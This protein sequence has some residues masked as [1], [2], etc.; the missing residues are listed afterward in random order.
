MEED[1]DSRRPE[2]GKNGDISGDRSLGKKE[3]ED[4]PDQDVGSLVLMAGNCQRRSHA[5]SFQQE[6][7]GFQG[8]WTDLSAAKCLVPPF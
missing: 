3:V 5:Q 6:L 1:N 7:M 2:T 8:R 4:R